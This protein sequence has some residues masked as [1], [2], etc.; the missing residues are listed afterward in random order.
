MYFTHIFIKTYD[1]KQ[2]HI[3][4]FSSPNVTAIMCHGIISIK[5]NPLKLSNTS[6]AQ[7]S[8]T[9]K[10]THRLYKLR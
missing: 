10:M 3:C 1:N 8:L 5:P 4:D 6:R 9:H 7:Q 2:V